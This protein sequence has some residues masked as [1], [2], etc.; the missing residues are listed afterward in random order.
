M[1]RAELVASRAEQKAE[2]EEN[3]WTAVNAINFEN[4]IKAIIP[5]SASPPVN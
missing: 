5:P 3:K 1:I 2:A 4:L